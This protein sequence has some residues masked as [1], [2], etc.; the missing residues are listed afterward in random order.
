[1]K[2]MMKVIRTED[3]NIVQA[4]DWTFTPS[5][6]PVAILTGRLASEKLLK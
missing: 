6:F 1:M 5:G 4:G 3:A 2:K